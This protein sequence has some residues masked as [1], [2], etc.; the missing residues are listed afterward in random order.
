MDNTKIIL[1]DC[2]D[3]YKI[4]DELNDILNLELINVNNEKNLDF[5]TKNFNSYLLIIKKNQKN[6]NQIVLDSLPISIV[7]LVEKI[8]LGILKNNFISKSNIQIGRYSLNTNSREVSFEKKIIKLTE[9]ETKILIYLVKNDS[10]VKVETLQK[11]IWGYGKDLET[12]TVETH[13]HRLK[14]KF[15]TFFKDK[16]FILSTKEGYKIK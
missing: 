12:H 9:K 4:L 6:K 8:N 3:I 5:Y 7:K 13:I 11:D 15:K 10:S 2:I 14:K 16:D 1:Y